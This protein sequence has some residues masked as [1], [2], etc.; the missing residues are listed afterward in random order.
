M[1]T[2]VADKRKAREWF[3]SWQN[4]DGEALARLLEH[5]RARMLDHARII[6]ERLGSRADPEEL[7]NIA[8]EQVSKKKPGTVENLS[9]FEKYLEYLLKEG[10]MVRETTR[11]SFSRIIEP[12]DSDDGGF[13]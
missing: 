4:G 12:D 6:V 8:S 2:E 13:R 11:D 10:I 3:Q 5:E 9:Q 7:V 1:K